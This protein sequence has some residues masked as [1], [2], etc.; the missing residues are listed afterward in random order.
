MISICKV[1]ASLPEEYR[2]E[3]NVICIHRQ[4]R[5][6]KIQVVDRVSIQLFHPTL[7]PSES[8]LIRTLK[9]SW[10]WVLGTGNIVIVLELTFI[11]GVNCLIKSYLALITK[12][13]IK[14]KRR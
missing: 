4:H 14:T 8:E 10:Y 13:T 12:K 11:F 1:S 5:Y 2:Y 9:I 3:T 7:A 6:L